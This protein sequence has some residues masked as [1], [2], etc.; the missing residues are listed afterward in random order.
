MSDSAGT[1]DLEI[2]VEVDPDEFELGD[3][4]EVE[5]QLDTDGLTIEAKATVEVEGE[6]R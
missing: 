5:G 4:R 1:V 3:R 2:E 6:Y